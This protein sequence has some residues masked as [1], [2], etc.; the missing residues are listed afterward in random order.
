LK[1]LWKIILA[2][3]I[4]LAVILVPTA[5]SAITYDSTLLLENKDPS[6]W[7]VIPD[8]RAGTL[9]YNSSGS[10]FNFSF[11]A[12]GLEATTEYSLIYYANPY[13]GNNPGKLIGTGTSDGIGALTISGTPDLGMSL[14]T[15]PDSNMV[16][17]HAGTPDFYLHPFGA[18]IWLVPSADYDTA[19]SKM[20]AWNPA[21]YLFETDLINYVDTDAGSGTGL[22]LTTTITE[23]A[24]TIGLSIS[25]VSLDFGS[26]QVG[27][28]S[29]PA[30]TITLTNTGSIPIVVTASTSAGFYTDCLKLDSLAANGWTS[31]QIPAGGHY[32]VAATICPT[33]A[34]NGTI[35]G[36]VNFV[37]SFSP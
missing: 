28:C 1:H 24:A 34:Y 4:V 37:A 20:I 23:P 31:P 14:P 9:E 7:I 35:T 26:V 10:T 21:S 36:S 22:P 5:A 15:V 18:K 12:T 11:T 6:T 8:G 13:P 33:I 16:T 2:M 25:P 19:L 3:A 29:S 30:S 27:T 17:S 32:D